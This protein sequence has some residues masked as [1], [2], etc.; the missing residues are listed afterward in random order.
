MEKFYIT[1]NASS[2]IKRKTLESAL[3]TV[4]DELETIILNNPEDL[5]DIDITY[6]P[7]E[8]A[9]D[10][11]VILFDKEKKLLLDLYES[12]K[13][14]IDELKNHEA[15]VGEEVSTDFEEGYNAALEYVFNLLGIKY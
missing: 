13:Y 9:E 15:L 11:N 8:K 1:S 10:L 3:E 7:E 5:I 14:T 6:Y 2:G 12:N 4:K